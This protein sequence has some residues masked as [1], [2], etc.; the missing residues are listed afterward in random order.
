VFRTTD[1][2]SQ[3]ISALNS[4]ATAPLHD[5]GDEPSLS[6]IDEDDDESEDEEDEEN[7]LHSGAGKSPDDDNKADQVDAITAVQRDSCA[8]ERLLAHYA[9]ERSDGRSI[10]L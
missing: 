6:N 7:T 9:R 2:R 3:A 8:C 4:S 5:A 10:D 1:E